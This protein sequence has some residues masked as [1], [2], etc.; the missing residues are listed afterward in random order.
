[1]PQSWKLPYNTD[2]DWVIDATRIRQELGYSELI[3]FDEALRRT[4]EWD[5]QHPPD[6]ISK[7]TSPEL[8]DY[9]T[10][11]AILASRVLD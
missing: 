2:Q 5:R 6:D 8:L 9:A 10:E 7:W 4:I 1:M 11:D 3:P